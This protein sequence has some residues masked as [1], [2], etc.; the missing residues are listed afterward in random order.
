MSEIEKTTEGI[1]PKDKS[2]GFDK[3]FILIILFTIAGFAA[4]IAA[5]LMIPQVSENVKI[6]IYQ[7]GPI[8]A[9]MNNAYTWVLLALIALYL[10]IG[11]FSAF[12]KERRKKYRFRAP[13]RFAAGIALALWDLLGTKLQALPQPFFPGPAGIIEAFLIEGD[14][15]LQNTLYSL[16]LFSV[17]FLLGVIVGVGTG[18]LIGWFPKVYYW[19]S[20]VLNI[21]GVIPAV[22]WMPFALTL[23]PTPFSAAAFLIVI[24]TWFPVA[25][26]T[27]SGI[28]STPKAKFEAART[29]GGKTPYLVFH[30][31]IPHAMPQIFTGIETANAFSFTTLVMAEMMGQPGG[32]GYYINA[33]KVWSAYY[34]VF[35]AI[36]VM[37][38]LF[39]LI[40]WVVGLIKSRILRW[41]RGLLK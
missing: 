11:I 17:G 9:T 25:S 30:V 19:V 26:L 29:L 28:K 1:K 33:S 16:R 32:L 4:A 13:F 18:I 31:A 12:K 41:Q 22:A 38:I 15:I 24:C 36:V 6:E 40:T 21:T 5:N 37:A 27:A 34:K 7:V 2:D 10:G 3:K 8:Y 23:F 14:Y 20:P 35:A 39:S